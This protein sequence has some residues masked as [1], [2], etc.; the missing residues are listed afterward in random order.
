MG[1]MLS[2]E[3]LISLIADHESDRVELTIS[4]SEIQSPGGL[5]GLA[6]P[7]NFPSQTDCRNP[8]VAEAMANLGYVN[9]FGRG[10]ARAQA[11]LETN[12]NLPSFL[13]T[14]HRAP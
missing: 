11:A 2:T 6:S 4:T 14:L 5:Y 12:G 8:V 3:Q 10:V 7:E 13:V 1:L 9:R